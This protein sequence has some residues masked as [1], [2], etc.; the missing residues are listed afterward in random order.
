MKSREEAALDHRCPRAQLSVRDVKHYD[1]RTFLR[2]LARFPFEDAV[3]TVV[4][5]WDPDNNVPPLADP[6]FDSCANDAESG[7]RHFL[8]VAVG[9]ELPRQVLVSEDL[10]ESVW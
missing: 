6:A 8:A 5:E 4:G 1:A 7:L 9:H 10:A 3:G 2:K